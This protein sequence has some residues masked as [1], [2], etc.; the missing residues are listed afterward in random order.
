MDSISFDPAADD[1]DAFKRGDDE[2][3]AGRAKDLVLAAL[4]CEELGAVLQVR[5][6]DRP[7][8]MQTLRDAGLGECSH[9][10]GQLNRSEE[11]RVGKECR[12]RRSPYHLKT[13]G[14]GAQV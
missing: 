3:L 14:G 6:P 9:L 10:I 12:A 1:V 5:A 4:F 11:R 7:R 13:K 2:Q 8:V